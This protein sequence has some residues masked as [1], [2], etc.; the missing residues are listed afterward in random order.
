MRERGGLQE[1]SELFLFFPCSHSAS[2]SRKTF[3]LFFYV[4]NEPRSW[5]LNQPQDLG[6]QIPEWKETNG[7]LTTLF[8]PLQDPAFKTEL[9]GYCLRFSKPPGEMPVVWAVTLGWDHRDC[10]VKLNLQVPACGFLHTGSSSRIF[11]QTLHEQAPSLNCKF[12]L[13][14][15]IRQVENLYIYPPSPSVGRSNFRAVFWVNC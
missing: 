14:K 10:R 3:S 8:S 6:A 11:M 2:E 15:Q 12:R 9:R 1:T 13:P 7:L 5:Y 4:R